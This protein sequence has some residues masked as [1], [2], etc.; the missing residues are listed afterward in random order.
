MHSCQK[1]LAL[2]EWMPLPFF[3]RS[4]LFI[5]SDILASLFAHRFGYTERLNICYFSASLMNW[6]LCF[7]S[8][9]WVKV[10]VIVFFNQV[11]LFRF[12]FNVKKRGPHC[13]YL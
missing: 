6:L 1:D 4:A 7:Q 8:Q 9:I 11:L 5:T 10:K 2:Q 3:G 13:F 12:I